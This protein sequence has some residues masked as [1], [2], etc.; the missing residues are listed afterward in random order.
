VLGFCRGALVS[1]PMFKSVIDFTRT[2][3]LLA[4]RG[5]ALDARLIFVLSALSAR[6]AK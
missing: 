1:A 3:L 6:P 5:G 4:A 2:R